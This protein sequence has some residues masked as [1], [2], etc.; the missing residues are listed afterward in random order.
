M[1]N[2]D[3]EVTILKLL[4]EKLPVPKVYEYGRYGDYKYIVLSKLEGDKLST[5]IKITNDKSRNYLFSYG[6]WL[7]KIHSLKLK[8]DI[9]MQRPINDYPNIEKYKDLNKDEKKIINYLIN[10]KPDI[11][12]DTFIHGDFHYGNILWKGKKITGI[13]DFEYAG[14]GFKEQ[15]IAWALILRPNQEFLCEKAEIKLFFDGYKT[16]GNYDFDKLKWCLINGYMHFYL[17]N[18]NSDNKKYLDKLIELIDM[19]MII[20]TEEKLIMKII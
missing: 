2:F 10:N 14:I 20:K 8:S 15:D 11:V 19:L 9:A 5:I 12:F 3:N 18:R 6:S 7:A 4:K 17:M 16:I 13:L 1:S